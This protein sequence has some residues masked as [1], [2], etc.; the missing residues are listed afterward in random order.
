MT[1]HRFECIH[2]F[3][4]ITTARQEAEYQDDPL[5]KIRPLYDHI[6]KCC[7]ELYQPVRELSVDERMVHSK[8][9]THF[10]QYIR[11][12]P[13]KWGF[14]FWVLADC[15]G[16]T[17]DLN[18]YCG[19]RRTGTPS[20][21]GLSYDVVKE[22]VEKYQNQGYYL[23]MDN[24][25]TSP[26]LVNYLETVGIKATGT[27][28][29]KRRNVPKEVQELQAALK[30]K[31]VPRGTGYYIRPLNSSTVYVCW[32]DND[33]VT[34]MSTAH[35]GHQDGTVKRRGKDGTGASVTLDLP[36][37][38]IIKRYN[39]CMGG[40]DKSVKKIKQNHFIIRVSNVTYKILYNTNEAY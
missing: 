36:F 29:T 7:A 31:G 21:N 34:L 8:A 2:A 37:P 12:K 39:E 30:K 35:P 32:R 25:Y 14:K 9:R 17:L 4:H 16:Y 10:R 1:H 18:L 24:F 38:C 6:K 40:V 20:G 13:T 27:V 22:L 5:C 23:Y 26:T 11:N 33:C 19:Q 3:L 15:T 28:N